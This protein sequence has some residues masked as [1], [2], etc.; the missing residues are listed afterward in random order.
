MSTI[1]PGDWIC[2]SCGMH[3]FAKSLNVNIKTKLGDWKCTCGE[4]NFASR[5]KCRKC[6][7]KKI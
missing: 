4:I 1:K 5:N 6:N 3:N 2:Q 7:N